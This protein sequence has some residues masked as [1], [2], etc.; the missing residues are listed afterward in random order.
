MRLKGKVAIVTGGAQGFGE[1]IVRAFLGEGAKV[2]I[3]D[4]KTAEAAALAKELGK[5]TAAFACDVASLASVREAVAAVVRHF[6]RLDIVVNNA[7][8]TYSNKP[9]TETTEAEFDKVFAVNVKSIYNFTATATEHLA[10][11]QGSFI[12][13]GSTAGIRPR[14]G[15]VW[16][17][18]TKGAVHNATK[19]LAV[20]LAPRKIRVNAIA[21]VAG[22]TPLLASFMGTDTPE[23][24]AQFLATIPLGRFSQ[25]RDIA[26]AAVFLASAESEFITGVVLEVDGGRCV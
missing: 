5:D 4:I 15:L 2:A 20:E 1:G 22:E 13:I 9:A 12:N 8:W 10:A 23:R 19:V 3:L 7:G 6:G 25:P 11:T 16:Y 21:P 14:P 18:A 26:N 24:R 17:N